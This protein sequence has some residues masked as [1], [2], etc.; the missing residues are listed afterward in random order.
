MKN[1]ETYDFEMFSK[2]GNNACRSAV[3]KVVKKISG[4]KRITKEEITQ[5]CSE[6]IKGIANKHGEVNDTEPEWHIADLVN[7][8]LEQSGYQFKVSRYDFY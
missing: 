6:L 8:S 3:K 1:L 4:N 5:Y 2:A 7:E